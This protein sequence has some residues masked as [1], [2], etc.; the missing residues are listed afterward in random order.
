M[1]Q[2]LQVQYKYLLCLS[3]YV[4]RAISQQH[5][6]WSRGWRSRSFSPVDAIA[7]YSPQT[8]HMSHTHVYYAFLN[9]KNTINVQITHLIRLKQPNINTTSTV[10]RVDLRHQHAFVHLTRSDVRSVEF[11][12]TALIIDIFRKITVIDVVNCNKITIIAALKERI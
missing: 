7:F 6:P 8:Y 1:W 5:R 12:V 9:S 4:L 3:Q 2:L 11:L 10:T